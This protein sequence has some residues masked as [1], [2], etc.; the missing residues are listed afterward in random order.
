MLH[1]SVV[2]E[3]MLYFCIWF[4][5]YLFKPKKK[6]T[7]SLLLNTVASTLTIY[8]FSLPIIAQNEL[9]LQPHKRSIFFM[10]AFVFD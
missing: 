2:C 4:C 5:I 9:Q 1:C 6:K 8:I 10:W 7:H 3:I